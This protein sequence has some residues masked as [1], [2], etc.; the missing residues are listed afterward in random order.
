[1]FYL[2]AFLHM[3]G[4]VGVPS[5]PGAF[6]VEIPDPIGLGTVV[7]NFFRTVFGTAGADVRDFSMGDL[8]DTLN[9]MCGVDYLLLKASFLGAIFQPELE[10]DWGYP[11]ASF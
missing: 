9:S 1:M 5:L 7:E 3:V 11:F 10:H 2:R 6:G 8:V 4:V